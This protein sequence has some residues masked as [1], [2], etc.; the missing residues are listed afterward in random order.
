[1]LRRLSADGGGVTA[2]G[3]L[4]PN[5]TSRWGLGD[6][7]GHEQPVVERTTKLWFALGGGI[8]DGTVAPFRTIRRRD[9]CSTSS[10]CA[11]F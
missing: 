8:G 9:A 6:A 11:P 4:V 2:I 5:T 3:G 10:V 7:R 1:V